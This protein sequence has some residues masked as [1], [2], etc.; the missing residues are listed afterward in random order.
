MRQSG[1]ILRF[2]DVVLIL[3]FGFISI[4]S[5]DRSMVDPPE[6]AET[7]VLQPDREEVVFV[8]IQR[9]GTMLVEDEAQRL[10]SLRA[11][12]AY[13]QQKRQQYGDVPM[14]VRLRSSQ[15]AP[16]RYLMDAASLCDQMGIRKS[17][18]VKI[19]RSR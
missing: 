15:T 3:L 2:V 7:P 1:Y 17:I 19:N 16:M 4:S 10:G 13:L 18:E 14:K 9:N 12:Q 11:L 6:S 5:I 8:S